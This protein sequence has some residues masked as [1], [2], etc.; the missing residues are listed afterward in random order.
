MTNT[1][2]KN[3]EKMHCTCTPTQFHMATSEHLMA[4]ASGLGPRSYIDLSIQ[5][6]TVRDWDKEVFVGGLRS[7]LLS[8][9]CSDSITF[10]FN[11]LDTTWITLY[12]YSFQF[13]ICQPGLVWVRGEFF[14]CSNDQVARGEKSVCGQSK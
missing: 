11:P 14:H 8:T 13:I 3:Q 10:K 2:T 4:S 6:Y 5:S 1:N 12:S 9:P 7:H